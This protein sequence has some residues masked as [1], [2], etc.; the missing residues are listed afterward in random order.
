MKKI[1]IRDARAD[2]LREASALCLRS[3]AHWGYDQ[4]FIDACVEALTLSPEVLEE[5]VVRVA[6]DGNGQI[7]GVCQVLGDA[8][9]CWLDKLF[10]APEAM[11]SGLGRKLF[12]ECVR[13]A[14]T[15][16]ARELVIASDPYAQP[17]YEKMGAVEEGKIASEAIAGRFLPRLV[18]RLQDTL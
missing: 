16:Q 13:I 1:C 8:D 10:I 9:E 2:D 3:K 17:F 6:V 11:G 12:D 15:L 14:R 5:A 4:V 7:I 18:Y